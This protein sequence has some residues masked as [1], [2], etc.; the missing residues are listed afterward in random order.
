MTAAGA[1]AA[2]AGT[3]AAVVAAAAGATA[4]AVV[5]GAGMVAAAAAGTNRH[6]VPG[7]AAMT[8]PLPPAARALLGRLVRSPGPW[9][10]SGLPD[11]DR[12]AMQALLAGGLVEQHRDVYRPTPAARD[13]SPDTRPPS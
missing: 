7:E 11:A 12:P 10:V 8:D 5:V 6:P 2:G 13:L 1:A 3:A 4:V 9:R